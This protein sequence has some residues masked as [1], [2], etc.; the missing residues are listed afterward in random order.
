MLLIAFAHFLPPIFQTGKVHRSCA[1][2][3]V[4]AKNISEGEK[5]RSLYSDLLFFIPLADTLNRNW[6][7][8]P[9]SRFES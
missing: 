9:L 7:I 5:S 4:V 6:K 8:E 1:C 2:V 3:C